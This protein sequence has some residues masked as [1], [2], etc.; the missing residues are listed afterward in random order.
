MPDLEPAFLRRKFGLSE[1]WRLYLLH[2]FLSFLNLLSI[3]FHR[4]SLT[5]FFAIGFKLIYFC[6]F[7]CSWALGLYFKYSHIF[8]YGAALVAS[9]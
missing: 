3:T 4:Q 9:F 7:R 1:F 8:I 6:L 2:G 5:G